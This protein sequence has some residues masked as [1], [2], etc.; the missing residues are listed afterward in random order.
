[1]E[2]RVSTAVRQLQMLS[3]ADWLAHARCAVRPM[4]LH[5]IEES[6]VHRN[7][8]TVRDQWLA[9]NMLVSIGAFS[10]SI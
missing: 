1:M 6:I 3:H 2:L 4:E 10:L 5:A 8:R 7:P 9:G